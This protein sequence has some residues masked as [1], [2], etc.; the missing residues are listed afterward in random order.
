MALEAGIP[1]KFERVCTQTTIP[2]ARHLEDQV[3]PNVDRICAAAR[4]LLNA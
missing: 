3:L 2:Y 1:L 4:K